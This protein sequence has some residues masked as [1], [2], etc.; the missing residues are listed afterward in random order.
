MKLIDDFKRS[1]T[2]LRV[3]LTDQ[4]NLRCLYCTPAP[5]AK[6]GHEQLLSYE[7]LLRVI[8]LAVDLGITKVRLTGGEPLVRRGII[9]FIDG[10]SAINGLEDVRLTTNGVFLSKYARPLHDAGVRKVNISLDSLHPERIKSITGVDCFSQVWQGIE[11]ALAMGFKVKLNMV[12]MRGV[13]DDEIVEFARLAQR[14]PL[15]VRYIEFMPIGNSAS[16]GQDRFIAS[17]ESQAMIAEALGTLVP[18][19]RNFGAGPA[20]I[21]SLAGGGEG[22]LGFI[23]PLTHKFCDLCNRLRLTSEGQLRSCLLSDDEADLRQLLRSGASDGELQQLIVATIKNKPQ[24]HALAR[25]KGKG[26]CQ[27]RMSRIGG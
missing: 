2:Y 16:W 15:Q 7:E 24:G 26:S 21:F 17:E 13:N 6:I 27:G 20:R 5:L 25:E 22:S 9:N 12:T 23:S 19:N 1:I 3:S 4:C 10:L 8:G 14:Y 11:D 18:V